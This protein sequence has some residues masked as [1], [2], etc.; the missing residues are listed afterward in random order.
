MVQP[1]AQKELGLPVIHLFN[2][3]IPRNMR[4]LN[5]CKKILELKQGISKQVW[6][7]NLQ[8]FNYFILKYPGFAFSKVGRSDINTRGKVLNKFLGGYIVTLEPLS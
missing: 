5:H 2:K 3:S 4:S 6:P 8:V 1:T 7:I